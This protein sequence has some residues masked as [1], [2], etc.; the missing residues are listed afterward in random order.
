MC[1]SPQFIN[2][3]LHEAVRSWVIVIYCGKLVN[4][5]ETLCKTALFTDLFEDVII[6][7][8][9]IHACKACMA[10]TWNIR[11]TNNNNNN[12]N[13]NATTQQQHTTTQQHTIAHNNTHQRTAAHNNTQQHSTTTQQQHNNTTIRNSTQ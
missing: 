1:G 8:G 9:G 10:R 12:T 7:A 3:P 2:M 11:A 4:N 5:E 6:E 13:N